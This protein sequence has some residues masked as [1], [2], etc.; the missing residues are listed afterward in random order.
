MKMNL[1]NGARPV[2]VP[3]LL[4]AT[5]ALR[6]VDWA[7]SF[8]SLTIRKSHNG[9]RPKCS[10]PD[11]RLCQEPTN[12]SMH[13]AGKTFDPRKEYVGRGP[14][15]DSS[16]LPRRAASRGLACIHRRIPAEH[17]TEE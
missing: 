12:S 16:P 9:L 1:E 3:G 14:L 8:S 7:R 15:G 17:L 5:K 4:L 2:D 11:S 10:D 6:L 13:A